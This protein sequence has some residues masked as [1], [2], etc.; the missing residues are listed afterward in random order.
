MYSFTHLFCVVCLGPAFPFSDIR[1]TLENRLD[2][3]L[4]KLDS[5][6]RLGYAAFALDMFGAGRALWD[7][8]ESLAARRPITEDRSLLQ[9]RALAAVQTLGRLEGVDSDRVAAVGYCFGGMVVLD[10][11]RMTPAV[12][13]LKA[14]ASLH[15]IL[16]PMLPGAGKNP[17]AENAA[18]GPKVLVLHA[19]D[20]PFVRPEQVRL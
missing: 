9:T 2:F 8:A 5:I 11:A 19:S 16:A 13:G 15:G 10:L 12:P 3:I 17:A 14:V 6:A 4:W 18:V 7:R 1:A 20:D